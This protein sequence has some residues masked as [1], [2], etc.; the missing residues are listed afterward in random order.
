MIPW[1]EV[2]DGSAFAGMPTEGSSPTEVWKSADQVRAAY[3]QSIEYTVNTLV[4]FVRTY[5]DPNLVLLVLGDHQP[6]KIVS[7]EGATHNVPVSIIA[8]DPAVLGR[9]APWG[10]EPGLLPSPQAP[11]WPMDTFRNRF[12]EAYG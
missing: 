2:G 9:I 10:W 11:V 3:G 7:G 6:A 5:P 1:N 8:H 12:L 4:S